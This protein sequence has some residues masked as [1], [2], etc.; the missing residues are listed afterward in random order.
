[1][2]SR[3]Y[4]GE[5]VVLGRKNFGEA[6]RILILYSRDH[7]KISLIAKGVRKPKSRKRGHIEIF[8]QIKFQA[9][10]T[11]SLDI[12]TEVETINPFENIRSDLKKISVAYYFVEVI[13]KSAHEGEKNSDAYYHLINHLN[14]LSES[15]AVGI[16]RKNFLTKLLILLGY[17]PDGMKMDNPDMVLEEVVERK[18]NSARVGKKVLQ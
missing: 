14:E 7:G 3:G 8:T 10:R 9:I 13:G 1:M 6:D 16:L 12:I 15:T 5:G 17:W 2:K 4:S 18:I 11:N